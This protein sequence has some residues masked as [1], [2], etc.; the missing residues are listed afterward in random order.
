MFAAA[1]TSYGWTSWWGVTYPAAHSQCNAITGVKESGSTCNVCHD[2]S[3][4]DFTIPMERNANTNRNSLSLNSTGAT[5][6]YIGG[7]SCASMSS[8]LIALPVCLLSS[9]ITNW[10]MASC[11]AFHSALFRLMS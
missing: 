1:G 11:T 3:Q 5:P 2:G 8:S 9:S 7:S 10:M 6:T 4:V